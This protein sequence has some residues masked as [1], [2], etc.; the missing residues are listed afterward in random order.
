MLVT[1]NDTS[2]TDFYKDIMN[3]ELFY[4]K[5]ND[6][7]ILQ[8][9]AYESEVYEKCPYCG[10]DVYIQDHYTITL[11]DAPIL[12]DSR[13]VFR[14]SIRR[15]QCRSCDHTFSEESTVKYPGTR[16]TRRAAVKIKFLLMLDISI[17]AV[18]RITGVNWGTISKIHKEE[19]DR[20]LEKRAD[21]LKR[22]GYKP[23]YLAVDE[24]AVHKG[25]TYATCVMDLD[26]GEILWVGKGRA[27][28]DFIH[29]FEDTDPD[30]LSEVKA[31]AMDMNTAYNQL[32]EEYLPNAQIVYDRYHMQAQYGRDVLGSVR[33]E[34][35]R[36]HQIKARD[37]RSGLTE[38]LTEAEK[39]DLREQIRK[40][41]QK[42]N[43]LKKSRWPLLRNG[44]SLSEATNETLQKI[45]AEH[46]KVSVCY[47]MKEEMC[48]L[49]EITDRT[50]AEKRWKEWF[51]AAKESGIQQLVRFAE[52]KE[53]R[54]DG[55]VSH[56]EHRISTGRLEGF[57]N[58][59]KVAKRIGYGYRNDEYFF[60]L[61]RY[62]SL[63]SV[64]GGFHKFS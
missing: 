34:E 56:A 49:F 58:R 8:C 57:N 9:T 62:L 35:A 17:S 2:I 42:Y 61:I 7:Y 64:R 30:M 51:R 5:E 10:G 1:V 23:K 33:L 43:N 27:L 40:E 12:P 21:E 48:E 20:V 26:T 45:L 36:E 16:I 37:M 38:D 32:V 55:L 39:K 15:Y 11:K 24:F 4:D 19:M 28:A 63:P 52:L 53:K 13:M 29:F 31:V 18:S 59:I 54:I 22:S 6:V 47:A 25:H 60:T 50:E 3:A 46:S 41:K 14:Q 44:T